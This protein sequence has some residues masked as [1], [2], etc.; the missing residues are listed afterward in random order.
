MAIPYTIL[1]VAIIEIAIMYSAAAM[2][3]GAT[4]AASRLI[5]TG[6]IQQAVD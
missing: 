3:E 1:S 4:G 6:Q 2:L 5:K